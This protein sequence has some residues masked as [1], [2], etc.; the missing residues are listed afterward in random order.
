M[1][2]AKNGAPVCSV[3]GVR[4][5]SLYDPVREASRF[6]EAEKNRLVSQNLSPALI[7]ITEPALSYTAEIFHG[8]FP[9]ARVCAVRYTRSFDRWNTGWD[10]VF[11]ACGTTGEALGE[12]LFAAF[13]EE[14]L[15][16]A[17]FLSWGASER[18]FPSESELAWGG[19]KAAVEK[20]RDVLAT[21]EYFSLRWLK[22]AL[23]FCGDV[24]RIAR[25]APGD[26]PVLI[27]ASGP[28][29]GGVIPFIRERGE[30]FFIIALSSAWGTLRSADIHCGLCVATD[31][32][33]WAKELLSPS[34]GDSGPRPVFA[35][36]PE[37]A[38]P[39]GLLRESPVLP[40]SYPDSSLAKTLLA[41][42]GIPPVTVE[43]NGTVSG[44]ALS[45]AFA[46]SAGPVFFCGLDLAPGAGYQHALP[47]PREDRERRG[48]GRLSPLAGRLA[49]EGFQAQGALGLYRRWF[50][51]R[52]FPRGVYRI[53]AGP[54]VAPLGTIRD[55]SPAEY[56]ALCL[57]GGRKPRLSALETP[58]GD[59]GA[60]AEA[61][62]ADLGRVKQGEDPRVFS[63]GELFP[64]GYTRALRSLHREA[65]LDALRDRTAGRIEE[66]LSF[67]GS[68]WGAE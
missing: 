19:I 52:V 36:S 20:S 11:Y 29:L 16:S 40:L 45:L 38:L 37:S 54:Y 44:T 53:S 24:G 25:F 68:I 42:R 62:R 12:A 4:L 26:S 57:K 1:G 41:L 58:S 60:V 43:R 51:A 39:G 34:G 7:F 63:L 28:S 31:G 18:A 47:N 23:R 10:R 8:L 2:T 46:L 3:R 67:L 13:G 33:F 32:G 35:L 22:N 9:G 65:E 27:A 56:D 14:A 15:C 17:A 61:L 49:Q 55:I 59:T 21:R 48:D 64:A 66:L 30:D 5:H 50:A 6:A